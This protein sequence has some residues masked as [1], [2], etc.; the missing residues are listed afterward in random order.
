MSGSFLLNRVSIFVQFLYN[1]PVIVPYLGIVAE[2]RFNNLRSSV[3]NFPKFI[4]NSAF[5][6]RDDRSGIALAHH[7]RDTPKC[8]FHSEDFGKLIFDFPID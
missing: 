2:S 3:Q 5:V 1:R 4:C 7:P 6:C 8:S